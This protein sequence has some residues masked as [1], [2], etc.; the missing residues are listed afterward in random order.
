MR[1]P[2]RLDQGVGKANERHCRRPGDG[3]PQEGGRGRC[4][5]SRRSGEE[6]P[7]PSAGGCPPAAGEQ[8]GP[9]RQTCAERQARRKACTCRFPRSADRHLGCNGR[10]FGRTGRQYVIGPHRRY[11]GGGRTA[12]GYY[13]GGLPVGLQAR[14][15]VPPGYADGQRLAHLHRPGFPGARVPGSHLLQRGPAAVCVGQHVHRDQEPADA[16]SA[17]AVQCFHHHGGRSRCL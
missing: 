6:R 13:Q 15:A 11:P 10:F 14:A 1:N 5:G 9:G 8:A 12:Q 3:I 16:E 17:P 7:Q 4:Q 2:R